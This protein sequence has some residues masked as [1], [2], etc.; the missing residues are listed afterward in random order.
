MKN[1]S[2]ALCAIVIALVLL[3]APLTTCAQTGWARQFN[4]MGNAISYAVVPAPNNSFLVAGDSLT[5]I[6]E[7]WHYVYH[8]VHLASIAPGGAALWMQTY[9]FRAPR[10]RRSRLGE[11]ILSLLQAR[12]THRASWAAAFIS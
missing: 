4:G 9:D 10:P 3:F 6:M 2:T 12:S 7:Y 11:G 5:L 1:H 8:H